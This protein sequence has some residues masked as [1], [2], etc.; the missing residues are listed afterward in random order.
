M[1]KRCSAPFLFG[2]RTNG[3][4]TLMLFN[5]E[6]RFQLVPYKSKN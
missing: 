1:Y 3:V 6:R 4:L 2:V 5:V